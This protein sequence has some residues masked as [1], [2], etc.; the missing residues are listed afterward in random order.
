MMKKTIL[1]ALFITA[2]LA[3]GNATLSWANRHFY[4]V[5][6]DFS[7]DPNTFFTQL[8]EMF[9]KL[10]SSDTQTTVETFVAGA[11]AGKLAT[12][13]LQEVIAL[14][15]LMSDRKMRVT[16]HYNNYL[17]ALN[18]M[19]ATAKNGKFTDW[20]NIVKDLLLK[21]EKAQYN[22]WLAFIAFSDNFFKEDLLD[23]TSGKKWQI[24]TA[25][26]RFNYQNQT[27]T[28]SFEE[29]S[30]L[31]STAKD[32]MYIINTKGEYF[33]LQN[34]WEGKSG[35][36][37]WERAGF[38]PNEVYCEIA[39]YAIDLQKTEYKVENATLY[40]KKYFNRPLKGVLEDMIWGKVNG[41][42][43]YPKFTSYELD[44]VMKNFAPQT[45]F[46][47]GFGMSG[48]QV[49]GYG[50]EGQRA[51]LSFYSKDTKKEVL[52][53]KST[54]FGLKEGKEVVAT[55]AAVS[56]YFAADSIYHPQL[57]LR[58]LMSGEP[59][60][61]LV[62]DGK[63][64]S[65]IAFMSSYHHME[66][67]LDAIF[68]K[69]NKPVVDM[70]MVTQLKDIPVI[71]ES[72]NLYEPQRLQNYRKVTDIDP[73]A[74]LY[75][76]S[77]G[78]QFTV[79]ANDFAKFLNPSYTAQTVYGVI[80]DLVADGFIYYDPDTDMITIRDKTDNYIRARKKEIDYDRILVV[81]KGSKENAQLDLDSKELLITGVNQVTLSDSQ[82]VKLFPQNGFLRV[83]KDRNMRMDG[84]IIAGS[85]DFAG[86]DFDFDYNPFL[87]NLDSVDQMK[88]YILEDN[89]K[90]KNKLIPVSTLIRSVS[91]T[92]FI[93]EANNK[94]GLKK[95]PSYPRFESKGNS[96]LYY[97]D[98]SLY[99]GAY[100]RDIFHFKLDPFKFTDLD[101]ITPDLLTFPGTM[102]TGDIFP[103][104]KQ[105]TSLQPDNSLGFVNKTDA[106]G[107]LTYKRGK[108]FGTLDMSNKGLIG[109]GRV[110]YLSSTL[111]SEN[112]IFLPD[113]MMAAA[114]SFYMVRKKVGAAEFPSAHNGKVNVRWR[115]NEQGMYVYMTTT[116]FSMFEDKVT[117]KGS[118]LVTDLGLRGKGTINWPDAAMRADAFAFTSGTFKSD[119]ADV[120]IK[121]KD[122]ARVSF[123]S[124]NVKARVDMD[125]YLGEFL[126][127]GNSI[128][129]D[130]PFNR[131]K[132]NAKEFYWLMKD[133]LVNLRMPEDPKLSYF[134]STDPKQD[135]LR[136]QA[137]GGVVN[138][139]DNT[140]KADGIAYIEIGD[141]RI[142]P[143][144]TQV[145][146]EP[147]ANIRTLENALIVADSTNEYHKLY[148][149][150]VKIKGR[151]EMDAN[152]E[153]RYRGK[154]L[155]RQDLF[156]EKIV[157]Q[158]DE[159]D[160]KRFYT[161]GTTNIPEN[162][163][164]KISPNISYKGS[165]ILDSREP[166][167]VFDGF[168]K[169]ELKT[170]A[171]L[172]QWFNF[173]DV[174]NPDSISID[175]SAP[176]GEFKDSLTFGILQDMELL[177]LY[178]TFLTKKR[179]S[180]DPY[181]FRAGGE[182]EYN[183]DKNIFR[184]ADKNR[185]SGKESQGNIFTL[186]DNTGEVTAEGK[187]DFGKDWGM[188]RL[189]VAGICNHKVGATGFDF[190]DLL[191]GF[192]FY[193]DDLLFTNMGD[194]IRYYNSGA[195]EV[196]YSKEN[197]YNA[198]VAM[199]DK[200]DLSDLKRMMSTY[201]YLSERKKG[202][203]HKLLLAN[204][205]MTF[206]TISRTFISNGKLGLSF[207]GD[208]YVNR[209]VDG[210][211]EIGLRQSGNYV[212]LYFET[213]QDEN[214][215]Y[216]WYFFHYK[217]G[218]L[219]ALS[220]DP[221][222]N[223]AILAAKDKKRVKENKAT[224]EVYQYTIA[225]MERRN[226]FVYTRRGEA[227]P[228][229]TPPPP[230]PDAPAPETP[231]PDTPAPDNNQDGGSNPDNKEGDGGGN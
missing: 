5:P 72:F 199:V 79:S 133:K 76:F 140:V 211:I 213:A 51:V 162:T 57:N 179:T 165:A 195:P 227:I 23:K 196:D 52:S 39:G 228:V 59:E 194:A 210:W 201:G 49:V 77:N 157:T 135:G 91:G 217:K 90:E 104:F 27:P 190:K 17:K 223:D 40:N 47:G 80:F 193:F 24:Q 22:D 110:E 166:F 29:A 126:A 226:V 205:Q 82:Q 125:Q 209:M 149:A 225:P 142:R 6:G 200:K 53:A 109:N 189:D 152:G 139:A 102:I 7:A 70:Q 61:R 75:A 10:K 37:T 214:K 117:L 36:V 112:F 30:L 172:S 175:V 198:A 105:T 73:V 123:N 50:T 183:A 89:D 26:Y 97:D 107:M 143:P 124:Y 148:K 127:N 69:I 55:K 113:S 141:A 158:A 86:K 21:A 84:T 147:D 215:N 132:T 169:I 114:D 100:K 71:F 219:Q 99:N 130:L 146:I 35:R 229:E 212:N 78:G 174:I 85:V 178:P 153:Y 54:F 87:I 145:F 185:L 156:F 58:Y 56:L 182:L 150:T 224:G 122:A 16:P 171:I 116:P 98:K 129:I 66:A 108:F 202:L 186:K 188:T 164:F 187:Y 180:L 181:L 128:P 111:L 42:Y 1:L 106:G 38:D 131:F 32:T 92:L 119:S 44:I 221:V 191:I 12:S 41:E 101:E 11:K 136:F 46:R 197:F 144:D 151:N 64:S 137:S 192:D 20:H 115:P 45:E 170:K 134:E 28:V 230:A 63:A 74:G 168:A 216:K 9:G 155:K 13:D 94:S 160:P 159:K 67:N 48:T 118:L 208:K 18:S 167:L 184:V 138:L 231:N 218:I 34:K 65:K 2:A 163:E 68:W 207:A 206:D 43:I 204:V 203:D 15:N 33:P 95:Y 14:C 31:C 121:N 177:D 96:Y 161:Y 88:I 60:L 120:Q 93:D 103:P 220:S 8:A 81:S 19:M 173:R 62:R 83:H 3:A 25:D 154:G 4:A 222:F 176:I